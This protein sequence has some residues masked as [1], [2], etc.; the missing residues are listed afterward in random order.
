MDPDHEPVPSLAENDRYSWQQAVT[1]FGAEGQ[2]R[3]RSASVL[4]SRIGGVGGAAATY[5]AA[6]GVGRL[7]LAHAGD[8][9]RNDL[10]RQTLMSTV[11]IGR[12]RVEQG[13]QRLLDLNPHVTVEAVPENVTAANASRLV[14]G[15]DLVVSAA[16]LFTERLLMNDEAVRQ[17][18]KLVDAAMY[19]H[20]LR[21][22][23][24]VPGGGAC[25]ACL[26]PAAPPHWRRDFPVL[27]AVAGAVGALAALEAI[28]LLVGCGESLAGRLWT[29]DTST[30]TSRIVMIPVRPDCPACKAGAS[31]GG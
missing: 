12:P 9:R 1:G 3:L 13:R 28:K 25:L 31:R 4:V 5:L 30:M 7:V 17:G 22:M 10:N 14:S 8:L 23:S 24:V 26:Y 16:P 20:E 2:R 21:L 29:L 18:R 19:D 11:G 15:C 27:G 6:A